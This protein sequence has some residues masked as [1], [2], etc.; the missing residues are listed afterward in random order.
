MKSFLLTAWMVILMSGFTSLNA[1][2]LAKLGIDT[3]FLVPKGLEVGQKAPDFQGQDQYGQSVSLDSLL[4]E[5]P[6]VLIFYR[7]DWCPVCNR[8]LGRFQDSLHMIISAGGQ[9]LAVTPETNDNIQNT[10]AKSKVGLKVMSDRDEKVMDAYGVKFRVTKGYQ[11][12]IKLGL[13][14]DIAINNGQEE[15]N[16]PVPATYIIGRDG[17]IRFRQFD[18]DYRVR[19][20]I[21]DM[22]GTLQEWNK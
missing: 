21:Q 14:D 15:A 4:K 18:L 11:N 7:G 16:L 13:G 9:V 22:I 17:I 20:S 6:V 8:Y 19:A 12:R 2:D 1:Q 10:L 3:S 5:G